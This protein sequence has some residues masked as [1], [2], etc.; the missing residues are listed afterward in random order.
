[1]EML[2]EQGTNTGSLNSF[3]NHQKLFSAIEGSSKKFQQ[4]T[5]QTTEILWF[6]FV[7]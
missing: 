5:N 2:E 4:Q 7:S 6:N 1:M 3:M